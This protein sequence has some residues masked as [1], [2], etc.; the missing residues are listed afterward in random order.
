[1]SV[2]VYECLLYVCVLGLGSGACYIR[3][4]L[5]SVCLVATAMTSWH[6]TAERRKEFPPSSSQT[7]RRDEVK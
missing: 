5:L 6:T 4:F 3:V 7:A 1:M 2:C